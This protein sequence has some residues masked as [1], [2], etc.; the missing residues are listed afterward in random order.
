[1]KDTGIGIPKEFQ[2]TIFERFR[3]AESSSKQEGV[4]LGLAICK[5][6]VELMGGKI[7]L[8]SEPEKGSIFSFTLPFTAQAIPLTHEELSQHIKLSPFLNILIAEDDDISYLFLH[9]SL[10][11]KNIVTYR[12]SNGAEA[13]D[14]IKAKPV[15]V[16][17]MDIRMPILSGIDA[18]REIKKIRP[19]TPIIAQSAFATEKEIH[20]SFEAGCDDY[21]TKPID[22]DMLMNKISF[23]TAPEDH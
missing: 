22:I 8:E 12:V 16:I 4:G 23:F 17:L 14:F 7:S 13:V 3:Q 20:H 10:S 9:E 6:Y 19:E 18:I 1:V 15:D 21:I 2:H 11:Q 5:A